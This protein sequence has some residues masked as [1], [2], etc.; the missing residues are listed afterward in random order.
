MSGAHCHSDDVSWP[1]GPVPCAGERSHHMERYGWRYGDATCAVGIAD[2]DHPFRGSIACLAA[3][4]TAPYCDATQ[5]S[6]KEEWHDTC[7]GAP[8]LSP[9]L[10]LARRRA[11][12][13][14]QLE[15]TS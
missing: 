10:G 13:S 15:D 3:Y 7:H 14:T 4:A 8:P 2:A 9:S 12:G 11:I 6:R 1:N 5:W